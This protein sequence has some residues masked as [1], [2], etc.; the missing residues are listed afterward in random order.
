MRLSTPLEEW[1]AAQSY[2]ATTAELADAHGDVEVELPNGSETLR[3]VL[4]RL[5][6]ETVDSAEEARQATYSALGEGAI[7]RKAY[8]D[9]D[10]TAMGE[11]GPEPL[12]L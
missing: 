5:P 4:S 10:P 8:S 11:G 12:S 3:E 7:G 9:R 6:E 1:F 2:P